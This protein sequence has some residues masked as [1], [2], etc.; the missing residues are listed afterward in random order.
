MLQESIE[1]CEVLLK[2]KIKHLEELKNIY[3][4]YKDSDSLNTFKFLEWKQDK[5]EKELKQFEI[6]SSI[7]LYFLR[8]LEFDMRRLE[9]QISEIEYRLKSFK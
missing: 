9:Q 5:T 7:L 3:E 1:C 2:L 4:K 6:T 8:P